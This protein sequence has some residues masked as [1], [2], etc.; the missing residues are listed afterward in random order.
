MTGEMSLDWTTAPSIETIRSP[1]C[2]PAVAAGEPAVTAST[3]VVAFPADVMKSPV[4]RTSA[5]RMLAAGPAAIAATR[6]HVAA[7][8]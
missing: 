7:R 6:F 3:V 8:Q 4:K 2:R 5:S 1:D